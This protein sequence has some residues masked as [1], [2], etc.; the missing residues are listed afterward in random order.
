MDAPM[1]GCSALLGMDAPMAGCEAM[2]RMDVP[3][4]CCEALLGMDAP[5]P[6]RKNDFG[7]ANKCPALR[8]G[9]L[10]ALFV[11]GSMVKS[12]KL[13]QDVASYEPSLGGFPLHH[14]STR[15]QLEPKWIWI[16]DYSP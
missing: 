9:D 2:L 1:A 16:I 7:L 5:G 8:L 6:P 4:A 15:S 14:H 10:H 12:T 3:M 11:C 13:E